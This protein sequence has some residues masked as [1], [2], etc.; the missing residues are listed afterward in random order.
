MNNI[1]ELWKS[2]KELT[3]ETDELKVR[4]ENK[5][6]EI[7]DTIIAWCAE[8]ISECKCSLPSVIDLGLTVSGYG[9]DKELSIYC[10]NCHIFD[11]WK[12]ACFTAG[13]HG[14]DRNNDYLKVFV[15]RHWQEIKVIIMDCL[16]KEQA[17]AIKRRISDYEKEKELDKD[18]SSFEL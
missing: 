18:L 11:D 10:S 2:V 5:A 8:K 6:N 1:D 4:N 3:K 12:G 16:A 15:I 9:Y 14:D 13:R 7:F 17:K